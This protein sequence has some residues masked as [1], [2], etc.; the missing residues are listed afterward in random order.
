MWL[1]SQTHRVKDFLVGVRLFSLTKVSDL[2]PTSVAHTLTRIGTKL[3]VPHRFTQL[4]VVTEVETATVT[5]RYFVADLWNFRST[6]IAFDHHCLKTCAR[7]PVGEFASSRFLR[8]L[9]PTRV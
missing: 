7:K 4:Y 1:L 2:Q 6:P 5:T 9:A 3:D 8:L